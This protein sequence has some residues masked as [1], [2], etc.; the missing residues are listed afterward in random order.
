MDTTKLKSRTFQQSTKVATGPKP[1]GPNL[2]TETPAERQQRMQDEL[3]G[4]KR[5][6][7]NASGPTEDESDEKR[8]KRERDYHLK[9]EVERHN[10]RFP[11]AIMRGDPS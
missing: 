2:W 11:I 3:M 8:R 4:V 6:V 9:E 5:K 10:V 7:E 1:S